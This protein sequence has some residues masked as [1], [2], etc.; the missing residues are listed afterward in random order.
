MANQAA[1]RLFVVISEP[2]YQVHQEANG[3]ASITATSLVCYNPQSGIVEQ[4]DDRKIA[5]ILTDTDYDRQSFRAVLFNLPNAKERI[6]KELCDAFK[7]NI[8]P[9]KWERMKSARTLPFDPPVSGGNVAVKVIDNTGVEHL[10][11]LTEADFP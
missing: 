10:F 5:A 9:D 4:T 6:L 7:R 11:M 2:E 8:D 3:Q 1:D